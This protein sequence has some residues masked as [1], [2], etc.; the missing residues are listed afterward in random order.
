MTLGGWTAVRLVIVVAFAAMAPEV[1]ATDVI[2]ENAPTSQS[3]DEAWWTGSLLSASAATLPPGHWLVEPF[4]TDAI[5]DAYYDSSGNRHSAPRLEDVGAAAYIM[6]GLVDGFS[7]G[8][9][10][11]VALSQHSSTE[12]SSGF[13]A[14][15]VT[16][17]SQLR[18]TRF[19]PDGWV[20]ATSLLLEETVPSGRYDRLSN[21]LAAGTGGGAYT[22]EVAVYAQTIVHAYRSRPLRIRINLTYGRSDSVAL[23][24]VS[25]Y[26]TPVGFVGHAHPGA[27]V[28]GVS[29]WEYS[30]TRNW[31]LALDLVYQHQNNTQVSGYA[32]ATLSGLDG[33][34][35][36]QTNS[37]ADALWSLAPALEY[38]FNANIGVIAGARLPV[39][40]RNAGRSVIPAL[41]LNMF[42]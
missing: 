12:G 10:P 4:A 32:P 33:T 2:T 39:A 19:D 40:G 9:L 17:I 37:G 24:D 30:I 20:P 26:G 13:A 31:V 1:S 5:T 42:F 34:A 8:M 18:L 11:H 29:A 22:T 38:N 27:A 25:V 14:G 23:R 16:L 41:A 3:G 6:Y 7:I 21:G 36:Y 15:D 35:P 28:T